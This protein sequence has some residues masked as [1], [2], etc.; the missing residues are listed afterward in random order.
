MAGVLGKAGVHFVSRGTARFKYVRLLQT[1]RE[2]REPSDSIRGDSFG[3]VLIETIDIASQQR[4]KILDEEKRF[5][6]ARLCRATAP[7]GER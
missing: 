4:R 5:T 1:A 2:E 3:E 6:A 7:K